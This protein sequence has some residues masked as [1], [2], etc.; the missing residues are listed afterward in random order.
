[1]VTPLVAFQPIPRSASFTVTVA[2]ANGKNYT[3]TLTR[4]AMV[5]GTRPT[6][7]IQ[8]A[9]NLELHDGPDHVHGHGHA[10]TLTQTVTS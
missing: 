7:T 10:R 8:R 1:M 6:Y 2:K 4:G 9:N 5:T 3:A